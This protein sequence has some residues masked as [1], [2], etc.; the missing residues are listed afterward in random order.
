[1]RFRRFLPVLVAGVMLATVNSAS[2]GD[3]VVGAGST[4]AEKVINQWAGDVSGQGVSVTYTG[5]GSGDGRTKLANG[6][7]DFAATDVPAPPADQDKLKAKY[8]GFVHAAITSAGIAVVYNVAELP[9]LKLTGPT[10]AKIFSGTVTNWNDPAIALD[11]GAA[12]PDLPIKVMVRAD[13]SGSSG[14]FTGYLEAAG[15]GNWKGGTTENFPAPANG[16]GRQGGG[17]LAQGVADTPGAVG[18]IDHGGAMAKSLSE[19]KVRNAAGSFIA[20]VP[21]SVRQ[22]IDEAKQNPDGTLTLTYTPKGVSAYPISTVS[23]ALAPNK[24]PAGK[25]DTFK[26]F[27]NYGLSKAGQDKVLG[28]GYAPLSDAVAAFSQKQ[29]DQITA[30]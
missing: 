13:K 1:M 8:G 30:G 12:G 4:F 6:E 28:L 20:P 5:T 24:L 16:E 7:V 25:A 14:V 18:Y 2:A 19:V 27:L 11:N 29:A 26:A 22:A 3:P 10:I 9:E 17:A 23:Y 15:G 21:E